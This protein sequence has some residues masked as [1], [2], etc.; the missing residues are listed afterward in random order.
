MALDQTASPGTH[1]PGPLYVEAN[2][3]AQTAFTALPATTDD[4]SGGTA[5]TTDY[6]LATIGDTST[7]NQGA[8]LNN[9]F[10]TIAALLDSI[11]ERI[12]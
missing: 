8:T 9:N 5:D 2:D 6:T 12:Q 10:A 4:Q 3:P 7:V 11:L 1:I